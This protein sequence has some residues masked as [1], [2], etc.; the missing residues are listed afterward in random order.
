[1]ESLEKTL[2]HLGVF[3]AQKG[4][5]HATFHPEKYCHIE[6]ISRSVGT[7][8]ENHCLTL[9]EPLTGEH[10]EGVGGGRLTGHSNT[11]RL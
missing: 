9:V 1:M 8:F 10:S 7:S 11:S 5:P 4:S 2:M 3:N 6:G